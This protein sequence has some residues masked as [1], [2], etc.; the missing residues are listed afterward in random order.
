MNEYEALRREI[1][2]RLWRQ[3][4]YKAVIGFIPTA[5]GHSD[6]QK[7]IEH[8]EKQLEYVGEYLREVA[9]DPWEDFLMEKRATQ[10]T[11][12]KAKGVGVVE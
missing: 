8:N 12:T 3:T 2:V 7:E 10:E 11:P 1:E 5:Q 9:K 6:M 4:I